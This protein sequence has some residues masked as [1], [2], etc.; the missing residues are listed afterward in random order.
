[1]RKL[2]SLDAL[3]ADFGPYAELQRL[4][5]AMRKYYWEIPKNDDERRQKEQAVDKF[6]SYF[7]GVPLLVDASPHLAKENLA[8]NLMRIGI[9]FGRMDEEAHIYNALGRPIRRVRGETQ[10]LMT[11]GQVLSQLG[12]KHEKMK[13]PAIEYLNKKIKGGYS[14]RM[15]AMPEAYMEREDALEILGWA[16]VGTPEWINPDLVRIAIEGAILPYCTDRVLIDNILFD[17]NKP[18]S[19][20]P[21]DF[22]LDYSEKACET[23]RTM[24]ELNPDLID[25]AAL[26]AE[27]VKKMAEG[28]MFEKKIFPIV[29]EAAEEV[30]DT[31]LD[32]MKEKLIPKN[33]VIRI[34]QSSPPDDLAL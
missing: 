30:Q 18:D 19:P 7:K 32:V 3:R 17:M 33:V 22:V 2:E 23:L 29:I 8:E 34:R 4:G 20:G 26:T 21:E 5:L 1:M 9:T 31:I 28:L 25:N 10:I 15:R 13:D 11:A 6:T 14:W 27:R 24:L 12:E 16:V